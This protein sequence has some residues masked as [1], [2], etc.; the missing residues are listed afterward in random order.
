MRYDTSVLFNSQAHSNSGNEV[1]ERVTCPY[2]PKHFSRTVEYYK[3]VNHSHLPLILM[4]WLQCTQVPLIV[5]LENFGSLLK[6]T[7]GCLLSDQSML[8]I[9]QYMPCLYWPRTKLVEWRVRWTRRV[10]VC[11]TPRNNIILL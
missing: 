10:T 9:R 2:C 4:E 5:S 7:N 6:V 1:L 3:H 11:A 8:Q